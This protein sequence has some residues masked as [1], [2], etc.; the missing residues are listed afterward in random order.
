[1]KLKFLVAAGLLALVV[2][3]LPLVASLTSP[4][5]VSAAQVAETQQTATFHVPGMFC[6][7]CPATVKKAM[8]RVEG[9]KSVTVDFEARTAIVAFDPA[10][11]TVAAIAAA[12]ANAGYPA[13]V[14]G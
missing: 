5:L 9:V 7:L 11:A 2:S 13:E 14:R 12:S 10:K 3:G 8:E 6:A 1:M 4:A